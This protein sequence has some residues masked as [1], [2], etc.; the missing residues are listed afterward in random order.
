MTHYCSL[1]LPQQPSRE[2]V[3][4][5]GTVSELPLQYP[6][7]THGQTDIN[8]DEEQEHGQTDIPEYV[9]GQ[10]DIPDYLHGQTDIPEFIHRQTDT[11]TAHHGKRHRDSANFSDEGESDEKHGNSTYVNCPYS[12]GTYSSFTDN[13]TSIAT[14]FNN[15]T[16][17]NIN[18]TTDTDN[19]NYT[20]TPIDEMTV[21]EGEV[22]MEMV[23]ESESNEQDNLISMLNNYDNDNYNNVRRTR[24]AVRCPRS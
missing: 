3:L 13:T 24:T 17:S 15:N 1:Q 6:P 19:N 21:Q 20:D 2:N 12:D 8:D 14:I 9:H 22:K 7:H 4:F 11:I 10:T 18:T 16:D 23:V 5:R